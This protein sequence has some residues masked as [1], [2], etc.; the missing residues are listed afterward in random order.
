MA[1]LPTTTGYQ[2]LGADI[3]LLPSTMLVRD[4]LALLRLFSEY[5]RF[6]AHFIGFVIASGLIPL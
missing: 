5:L 3:S 6:P 1:L 2:H 4:V